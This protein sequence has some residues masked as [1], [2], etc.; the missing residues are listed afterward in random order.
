METKKKSQTEDKKMKQ[1]IEDALREM[2]YHAHA[3]LDTENG[4]DFITKHLLKTF[5]DNHIVFYTNLAAVREDPKMM[6]KIRN[7]SMNTERGL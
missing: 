5:E 1:V 4:R 2:C 7:D 6:D 3:K